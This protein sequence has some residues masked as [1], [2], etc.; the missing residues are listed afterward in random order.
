MKLPEGNFGFLSA[1]VQTKF[2]DETK[3]AYE[4]KEYSIEYFVQKDLQFHTML[5]ETI[6]NSLVEKIGK[7][8]I[9]LFPSYIK[10]SLMQKNGV[11]KSIDN[12]Y[13]I[14]DVI[15]SRDKNKFFEVIESTLVEWKNK[16]KEE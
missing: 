9:E 10:K 1:L 2:L 13:K 4:S 5:L 15:K 7:T 8:I 11:S 16:W 6:N 14:L 12:H 3:K